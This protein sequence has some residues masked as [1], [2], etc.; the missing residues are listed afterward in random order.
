MKIVLLRHA[1]STGNEKRVVDSISTKFDYLS[2]RGK[3]EAEKLVKELRK[4][5]FDNI[6]ISPLK[7]TRQTIE[8]YVK[9]LHNPK[10]ITSK[11]TL[12]RNAGEFTDKPAKVLRDYRKDLSKREKIVFRPK[13]GESIIDTCKRAKKFADLLKKDFKNKTLLICGH[14]N[15][16]MCLEIVLKKKS[17]DNFYLYKPLKN[18]QIKEIKQKWKK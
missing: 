6:I 10:I 17:I 13:G 3:K 16:L 7:R 2:E 18:G 9:T 5:D 15:F 8:P 11:L 12:E 4:Y 1:H 14:K